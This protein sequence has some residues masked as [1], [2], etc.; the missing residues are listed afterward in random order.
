[1]WEYKSLRRIDFRMIPIVFCLMLISFF[2]ISSMTGEEGET[3]WTPL[4]KSQLRWYCVGWGV[5]FFAAG[6]DYRKLR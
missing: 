4:V 1:M 3:F 2:V 6:F 5:F